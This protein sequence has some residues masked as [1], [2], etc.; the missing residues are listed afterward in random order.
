MLPEHPSPQGP[1][2]VKML[3]IIEQWTE[4]G[5][6]M[7]N[8]RQYL[9]LVLVK[10]GLDAAVLYLCLRKLYSSFISI[11]SLS[12]F[13]ADVLMAI[14]LAAVWFLGPR[15]T[16][17]SLCFLLT[18]ASAIYAA[19]PLPVLSFALLDYFLGDTCM[20]NKRSCCR[21][22]RNIALTAL[23]WTVAVIYA[24]DSVKPELME[25]YYSSG[26]K[27]L[28]CEVQ[29]ST[30]IIDFVLGLFLIVFCTLLPYGC[31]IV[32][33]MKEAERLSSQREEPQE[34]QKSDLLFIA[35][36]DPETKVGELPLA[37][38]VN[39]ERP[40]LWLS[41]VLCFSSVWLPY[42]VISV[43]CLVLGFGVPAYLSVNLLWFECT[44]SV[45]VG[46]MFW[47]K[48]DRLGPYSNLPENVCPWN[49]YWHLSKGARMQP[50][51][52]AVFNPSREKRST[53]YYI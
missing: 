22:L 40:W 25:I 24:S 35:T 37:L 17:V 26:T 47:M 18:T 48:S 11:C 23:V 9:L 30:L 10:A 1:P 44:N 19:V 27:A 49:V 50:L 52:T 45:L 21:A 12:I 39:G 41:M 34:N 15:H 3:A 31:S 13:L 46:L 42:L 36:A 5:C 14:S 16:P 28:V 8:T 53:L 38:R 6:H 51:P 2:A 29:E 32:Q 7:D 4:T 20:G 43:T 33:W